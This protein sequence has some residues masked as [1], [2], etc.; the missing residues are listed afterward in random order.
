VRNYKLRRST[1][2]A[3]LA[4][5]YLILGDVATTTVIT[6]LGAVP[7]RPRVVILTYRP[8]RP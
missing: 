6:A 2:S 4:L 7:R 5:M 3:M 1:S 8:A